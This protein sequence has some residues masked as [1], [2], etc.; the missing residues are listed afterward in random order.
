MKELLGVAAHLLALRHV[1]AGATELLVDAI[2]SHSREM[3]GRHAVRTCA[4]LSGRLPPLVCQVNIVLG[5]QA[6]RCRFISRL[7]TCCIVVDLSVSG[8]GCI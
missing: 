6:S 4:D 1:A 7:S 8:F 3:L 5:E 2:A